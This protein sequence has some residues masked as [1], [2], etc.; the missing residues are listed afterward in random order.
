M[1]SGTNLSLGDACH[2]PI[3]GTSFTHASI[4]TTRPGGGGVGR[5]LLEFKAQG[6]RGAGFGIGVGGVGRGLGVKG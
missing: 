6:S 5:W 1:R 3:S 4:M 2:S